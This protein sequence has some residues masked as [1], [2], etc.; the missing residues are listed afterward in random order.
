VRVIAADLRFTKRPPFSKLDWL[1][2]VASSGLPGA[3]AGGSGGGGG[4]V[5][6]VIA[7][8]LAAEGRAHENMPLRSVT[9]KRTTLIFRGMASLEL[10]DLIR[11]PVH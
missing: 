1:Q 6:D 5:R 10:A 8:L 9:A 3:T 2:S 4:G 11:K 7:H